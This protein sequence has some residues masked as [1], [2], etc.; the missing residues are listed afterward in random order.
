MYYFDYETEKNIKK[1][2]KTNKNRQMK[3]LPV[4]KYKI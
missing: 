3:D 2:S 1:V 4:L